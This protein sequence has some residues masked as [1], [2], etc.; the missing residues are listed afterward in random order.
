MGFFGSSPRHLNAEQKKLLGFNEN[1]PIYLISHTTNDSCGSLWDRD[2]IC[3]YEPLL[4][5]EEKKES[6]YNG[7][8]EPLPY[9]LCLLVGVLL[10]KK[11]S[12]EGITTHRQICDHE[13]KW[14]KTSNHCD[15]LFWI[16]NAIIQKN[17]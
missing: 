5:D 15:L 11:T 9:A 8:F 12:D 3:I 17:N 4:Y 16:Y 1:D 10:L 13:N 6:Y 7:A 2:E 14:N